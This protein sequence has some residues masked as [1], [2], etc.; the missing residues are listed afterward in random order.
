MQKEFPVV[1]AMDHG[2]LEFMGPLLKSI[3][4]HVS[5]PRIYI[6]TDKAVEVSGC[7]VAVMENTFEN[8]YSRITGHTYYR[9]FIDVLFPELE[10]C[11]YLD[12]DTL[13]VSDI[14]DLLDGE[15][16]IL[17]AAADGVIRSFNAGVLA[18]R[19]TDE[20][21]SLMAEC[22]EMIG[23]ERYD[24]QSILNVVFRDHFTAIP[25]CYNV[26]GM[27]SQ[28]ASSDKIIHYIGSPK[29]WNLG[30]ALKY[31]MDAMYSEQQDNN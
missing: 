26:S 21:R 5:N 6:I 15:D 17:K 19:F 12:F 10:R 18:F 23:R 14:S 20:C 9:L 27:I 22:R 2:S 25:Y 13:V 28:R 29:P 24:D 31:Y 3:R 30:T 11:L 8:T 4:R 7:T 1:L 16:W